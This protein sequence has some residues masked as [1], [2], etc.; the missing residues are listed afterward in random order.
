[1]QRKD[2]RLLIGILL[3]TGGVV[4]LLQNLGIIQWGD[5]VWSVVFGLAGI[6]FLS[7]FARDRAMWWALIPGMTLLGL[8]VTLGL[9]YFAPAAGELWGGSVF[10]GAIGL[11]FI[12]VYAADRNMWW[13][14]IPGGVMLTLATVAALDN[15][16]GIQ[17][18][19]L[20]FIGLGLTFAALALLPTP[21]G[22][23][24]W[25][26]FPA[27]ALGLMGL[28]TMVGCMAAI[29]YLWP[30]ALIVG[31]LSKLLRA[32]RRPASS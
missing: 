30:V 19:G 4:Y 7:V 25:A 9:E 23:M 29:G 13:A 17:T 12:L 28:L 2:P 24:R 14:I 26:V 1:M 6:G 32:V 3:I 31:G 11:S 20:F 21:G 10:L 15:I 5:I 27:V 16:G 18:D 8:S 22:R